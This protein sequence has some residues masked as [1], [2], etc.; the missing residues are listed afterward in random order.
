[1]KI[2]FDAKRA[3]QN[4]TGLGHYSR[5]LIASLATSFPDHQYYLCAPK[6]TGLFNASVFPNIETITPVNFPSRKLRSLWRSKWV[7]KDLLSR[8]IDLY[9]GLSH[10]IPHGI[11]KSSVKSVVTI[12]DL[13]FER[14]PKQ[15]NPVDVLIYRKKFSYACKHANRI[16]AISQQTKNDIIDFYKTPA[17]KIDVCYQSC[18]PAFAV[19][20]DAE[21]KQR[22]K[23]LYKLPDTYFLYV[24]SIIERKNLL[25]ICKA[26]NTLKGILNIPL[27]V[28]GSGGKYK[29]QVI[30][31]CKENELLH[32]IHF[33]SDQATAVEPG[34]AT[35][36]DFP[37]IYQQALA[38]VYPSIFEGFGIPVLEA[39]ASKVPVITS[40]ISCLPETGGDAAYYIDP[41]SP[42]DIANAMIQLQ[43]DEQLRLQMIQKGWAHAQKFTPEACAANV[44]Q[45][46][47]RAV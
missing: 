5:T 11:S 27:V 34:F 29:Q 25:A 3:Y 9:H 24:G 39:M 7:M 19:Q 22:V 38:V 2:A 40:N 14:Y 12:H 36:A 18:N 28:I 31:Y 4:T 47:L 20:V 15:Y 42:V 30:E 46:Y 6:V 23:A 13:I 44:M 21:E 26:Y 37:A 41:Y 10:E 17:G 45:V 16:I 35:A 33:L 32:L 8:G 1:M 43:H